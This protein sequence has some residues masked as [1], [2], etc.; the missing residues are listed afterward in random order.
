MKVFILSLILLSTQLKAQ[1]FLTDFK[2]V[3]QQIGQSTV[4]NYLK[5]PTADGVPGS[6]FTSLLPAPTGEECDEKGEPKKT[7]Y[8]VILMSEISTQRT[9]FEILPGQQAVFNTNSLQTLMT[10]IPENMA[11]KGSDPA[12]ILA[13][14]NDIWKSGWFDVPSVEFDPRSAMGK[15]LFMESLVHASAQST[16]P[17]KELTS[18]MAR[19]IAQTYTTDEEKFSMLSA[20]SLRLYRNY[21]TARNPGY[22]NKFNNPFDHDLP[23]ADMTLNDMMKAAANYN[24][25]QG[26]VCNDISEMVALV[27]EQLFPD[28]DVLVI[29]SGSHFGVVIADGKQNRIIDGGDEMVMQNKLLLDPKMSP[30][31]LRINKMD[32]G[33]LR[34][35]AVVDTEMG[36]LTEAAFQTGKTLLKTDADISSLM[37]HY[38]NKNF[39][40]TVGTG[41]LSESNVMIVVAK[42][43]TSGDKWKSYLGVGATAQSFTQSDRPTK[44]QVHFRA[45]VERNMFR[46]VNESTEINLATGLR[47]NGMYALN[48]NQSSG[49][50]L[51]DMSMGL[52]MANRLDVNWG[53]HNPQGLQIK[54][55]I[56]VEHSAGLRNWGNAQGALS[57]IEVKDVPTVLKNMNFHLNQ[58]NADVTAEKKIKPNMTA[59]V[60][61]HYQGSNIGQ[62]V[63]ALAGLNIQAP[64]GA[65]ILVFTGYTN[66]KLPGY[67]TQHGLLASPSGF[68]VG[69]KYTTRRGIE[70]GGAVRSI[71]GKPSVQATIKVPLGKKK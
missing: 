44:Y 65:Q 21:N 66:N 10:Q 61:T 9:K 59:F 53:K 49:V 55:S 37:A 33:A 42:Y 56:E 23:A 22:D 39:G 14:A 70:F 64:S 29:N 67:Q 11:S 18:L 40:V 30:T 69:G 50:Q 47:M 45:G 2:N 31:N 28:K 26:G 71:S 16:L 43:E 5:K 24:D 54:S 48:Q 62:S 68:Q 27:G 12:N 41:K 13:R 35:I 15:E 4:D 34:Q 60:N 38:K 36:Q 32:N 8:E 3:N 51:V 63:S 6:I 19:T 57:Y 25:F 58:I 17:E 52:D 20:M 7:H 1:D 46:Y